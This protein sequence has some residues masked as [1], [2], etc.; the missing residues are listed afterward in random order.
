MYIKNVVYP[1]RNPILR[2]KGTPYPDSYNVDKSPKH[3]DEGKKLDTK[4]CIL[5]DSTCMECPE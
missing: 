5:F 4:E 3:Y 2:D 1:F